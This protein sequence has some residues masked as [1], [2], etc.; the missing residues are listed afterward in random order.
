[1]ELTTTEEG[2]PSALEELR[3]L[4]HGIWPAVLTEAGLATAL[5]TLGD[6]A[7][8]AVELGPVPAR[9]F[10]AAVEAA[11]YATV[12]E[13]IDD[14]ARRGATWVR[15][16]LEGNVRLMVEDDGSPRPARLVHIADRVGAL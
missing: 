13:A 10:G 7:S 14:A 15:V 5:E 16:E 9:R 3:Q 4:A 8:V 6:E 12:R 2:V 11:L 1:M